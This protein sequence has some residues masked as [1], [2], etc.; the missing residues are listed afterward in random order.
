MIIV[1]TIGFHNHSVPTGLI[2]GAEWDEDTLFLEP[3]AACVNTNLSTYWTLTESGIYGDTEGLVDHGRFINLNRTDPYP[4]FE[5]SGDGYPFIGG[6][7]DPMLYGR[8]YLTAWLANV[9]AMQY[10][11]IT[12]PTRIALGFRQR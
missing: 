12:E 7:S 5:T 4:E 10:L 3:V 1:G 9:Y 6:Q 8:V 2:Y 11:N